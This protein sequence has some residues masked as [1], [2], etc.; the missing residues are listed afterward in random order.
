[1]RI[2]GAAKGERLDSMIGFVENIMEFNEQQ[3]AAWNELATALRDS[4]GVVI[5]TCDGL[6][7]AGRPDSAPEKLAMVETALQ[8]GLATVQQVRPAFEKFYGTLSEKQRQALDD[9][10]SHHQ[11]RSR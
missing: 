8:T 6:R 10:A 2:C 1:M 3:Q 4:R 11:R 5:K 7:E 9:L